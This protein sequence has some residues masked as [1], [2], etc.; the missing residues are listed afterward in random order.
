MSLV[1]KWVV[2]LAA[3]LLATLPGREIFSAE[4]RLLTEGR[5][6]SIGS[7]DLDRN[8]RPDIVISDFLN[9]A[10]VLYPRRPRSRW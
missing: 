2:V 8:G 9:H 3:I 1:T 10:R 5:I 7:A 4:G 6:F